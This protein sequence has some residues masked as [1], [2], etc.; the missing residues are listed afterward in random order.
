[1]TRLLA[2]PQ[3]AVLLALCSL[4]LSGEA[5]ALDPELTTPYKVQVVLRVAPN[6]LLTPIF[7]EQLRRDLQQ[8]LQAALGAMGE[9][10]VI[11]LGEVEEDKQEPLWKEVAAKGLRAGFDGPAKG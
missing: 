7:K 9:V 3:A 11:D 8:G 5:R 4:C 1:M 6:R 2:K 10:E